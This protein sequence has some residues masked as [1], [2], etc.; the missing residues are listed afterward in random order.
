MRELQEPDAMI[1][2]VD[3]AHSASAGSAASG[4]ERVETAT[5]AELRIPVRAAYEKGCRKG[6]F[7]FGRL[8]GPQER[9]EER[10]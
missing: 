2:I 3:D 4:V 5:E 8:L 10:R 7:R 6:R 9:A 1:A